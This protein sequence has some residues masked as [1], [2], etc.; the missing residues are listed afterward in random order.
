MKRFLLVLALPI[1]VL[2]VGCSHPQREVTQDQNAETL[3]PKGDLITNS[4]FT[5]TAFLHIFLTNDTIFNTSMGNVT[6]EPK[7]RTNWHKHPGGQILLV[8][9]GTGYYQEKGEP[10]LK[11]QKGDVVKIP[12]FAEHWHGAAPDTGLAHLAISVN[13]DEGSV[14]W[15]NPVTDEEYTNSKK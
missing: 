5:G 1:T 6:F 8:T 12:P 13:N 4:N 10:A 15:L 3:F 2:L 7:A 9:D 11:I 14:V